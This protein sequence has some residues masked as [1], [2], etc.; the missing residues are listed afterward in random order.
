MNSVGLHGLA[1]ATVAVLIALV[2]LRAALHKVGDIDAFSTLVADYR[3]LPRW[4]I[5]G[6][7]RVVVVAEV[8]VSV[9]ILVPSAQSIGAMLAIVILVIYAL[10]MAVNLFRGHHELDCGCGG[11]PRQLAWSLVGRNLAL[12]GVAAIVTVPAA[13]ELPVSARV[14]AAVSGLALWL[15]LL[16]AEQLGANASHFRRELEHRMPS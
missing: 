1:S 4:A 13:T 5:Y 7:A 8:A 12:A 14:L 11:A 16:L 6:G 3:V 10:A 15:G 9:A 2:F